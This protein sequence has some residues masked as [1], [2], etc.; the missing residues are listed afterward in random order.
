LAASVA[1]AE[2]AGFTVMAA[3][4]LDII[5]RGTGEIENIF[6]TI[7]PGNMAIFTSP[8]AVEE[9]MRHPFVKD[10]LS[11]TFIVSIGSGTSKALEH[12]DIKVD[13]MP[14]EYSSEGLVKHLSASVKGK[15]VV[16]LRSDRGTRVLNEGL[17]AAGAEVAEFAVYGLMPADPER[18]NM[19]LDAGAAGKIDAFAFSSPLTARAFVEAAEKR[20]GNID[21]FT[22]ATVAAIGKPTEDAL[23]ALG[24]KVDIIPER[25]TFEGMI[26]AI[27]EKNV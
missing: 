15:R 7:K 2:A 21:M 6:R 4:S 12:A 26:N 24:I 9:C 22:N 27:K 23:I 10:S 11:G 13:T 19:I 20:F 18:L 17:T 25:E 3:P 8:T 5:S 14:K 16:L 1:F